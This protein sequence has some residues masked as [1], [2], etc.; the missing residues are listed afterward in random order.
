M[1]IVSQKTKK[2]SNV[3]QSN[4]D[5]ATGG[6]KE[7]DFVCSDL[8][9]NQEIRTLL[10]KDY[11]TCSRCDGLSKTDIKSE[12]NSIRAQIKKYKKN[13]FQQLDRHWVHTLIEA[14]PG[15]EPIEYIL[16]GLCEYPLLPNG[17]HI[18]KTKAIKPLSTKYYSEEILSMTLATLQTHKRAIIEYA[19]LGTKKEL[20][21]EYLIGVE[22]ENEKR[23]KLVC[24][25]MKDILMYLETLQF[26]INA[27]RN[28]VI[29]LG[30]GVLSLQ[31][32]CGDSGKKSGNQLA[33]KIIVS[34]LLGKVP[35]LEYSFL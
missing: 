3:S 20:Q 25:K 10:G 27:P 15:L 24:M 23:T 7:E 31:R 1:E 35:Y 21:P 5:A 30:D 12:D 22:Y 6:K 17:T 11:N 2:Q 4:S 16:R 14:I 26:K 19:F 8:N 28:T 34:K 29:A 18:D 33:F 9:T 32:K 13:Q